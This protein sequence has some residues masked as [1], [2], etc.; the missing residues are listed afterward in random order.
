MNN[1]FKGIIRHFG[2]YPYLTSCRDFHSKV[3]MVNMLLDT[4]DGL[5]SI[6]TESKGKQLESLLNA[7]Q[8]QGVN[9]T[10]GSH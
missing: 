9:K 4:G 8:H 2:K 6:K 7:W 3:R 10:P 5:L 1:L